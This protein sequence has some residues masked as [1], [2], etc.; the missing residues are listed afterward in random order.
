M[1]TRYNT[2]SFVEYI[3]RIKRTHLFSLSPPC[4]AA[5]QNASVVHAWVLSTCTS[6]NMCNV[7]S[8]HSVVH[9]CVYENIQHHLST[10]M[11]YEPMA[12]SC[13]PVPVRS[14]TMSSVPVRPRTAPQMTCPSSA[15]TS[16]SFMTPAAMAL[17]SSPTRLH[18]AVMSVTTFAFFIT[19]GG[20]SFFV[21]WSDPDAMISA[22]GLSHLCSSTHSPP[23]VCVKT[24]S[25]LRTASSAV[26]HATNEY[27]SSADN[28]SQN[29]ELLTTSRE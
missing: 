9:S 17:R 20:I 7:V 5:S 13:A 6:T 25:A 29:A 11:A 15:C 12:A 16:V 14:I 2:S 28:L 18:C 21:G 8:L 3:Q 24:T 27:P 22:W 1:Y 19:S 26:A 10:S 23:V 4:I